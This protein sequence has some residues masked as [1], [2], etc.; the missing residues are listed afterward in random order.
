MHG[1]KSTRWHDPQ[2]ATIESGNGAKPFSDPHARAARRDAHTAV[3]ATTLIQDA[4]RLLSGDCKWVCLT[5]ANLPGNHARHS[6]LSSETVGAC[7][8]DA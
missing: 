4:E 6:V 8:T 5:L 7:L 2:S 1:S 3:P